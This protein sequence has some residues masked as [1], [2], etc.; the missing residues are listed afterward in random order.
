VAIS[1][2]GG[3]GPVARPFVPP[4]LSA[5]PVGGG[6]EPAGAPAKTDFSRALSAASGLEASADV[7]A[8][9]VATGTATDLH[10]MTTASTKASLA[11]SMTVAV[12]NRAVEAYQEIMRMQV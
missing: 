12:R 11:V 8:A 10:Q 3:A 9:Q 1:S 2:I 4:T 6:A 5:A 7:A